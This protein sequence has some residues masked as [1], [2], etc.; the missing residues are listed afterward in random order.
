MDI[1]HPPSSIPVY[2]VEDLPEPP[3]NPRRIPLVEALI[4]QAGGPPDPTPD[5][6]SMRLVESISDADYCVI[7][8]Y[9]TVYQAASL[10]NHIIDLAAK[11]PD[12]HLI[13]WSAGDLESII[14]IKNVLQFQNGLHRSVNRLPK[15]SFELPAFWPDYLAIYCGGRQ[16]PRAKQIK[17]SIGFCGQASSRLHKMAYFALRNVAH[18]VAYRFGRTK[19]IPPPV[20]PP[21]LLRGQ[22]LRT[23]SASD[24]VECNFIIRD[25]YRAGVRSSSERK[26]P[27]HPA[28]VEFV[29]NI[30]GNDYTVCVRG[31]GNFSVRLYEVLSLGRIPIFIDT[32]SRLP[33]DFLL[34]WKEY[35]VWVDQKDVQRLPQI[36]R[37]FHDNLSDDAFIELQVKCRQLWHEWLSRAGFLQHFIEHLLYVAR[38]EQD[39]TGWSLS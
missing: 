22:V 4:A 30:L 21:M 12:K 39:H 33:Y 15:Y 13:V 28:K 19:T 5:S 9:W 24:Q 2:I 36:V 38:Q 37:D 35:G 25:R 34:D 27:F 6:P 14:P 3:G 23:L 10:T 29:N 32:D 7:P 20:K 18:S 16:K 17:P 11:H 26:D 8:Y 1:S 31:G